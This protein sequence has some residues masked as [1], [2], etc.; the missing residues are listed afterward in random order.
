MHFN[1]LAANMIWLERKND[2][3]RRISSR[4]ETQVLNFSIK[5]FRNVPIMKKWV[6]SKNFNKNF[7]KSELTYSEK[8]QVFQIFT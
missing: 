5:L 6:H 3:Y 7:R 4:H 8:K 2:L 1:M